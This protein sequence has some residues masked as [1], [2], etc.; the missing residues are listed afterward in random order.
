MHY[1]RSR[2][3]PKQLLRTPE[4]LFTGWGGPGNETKFVAGNSIDENL[5]KLLQLKLKKPHDHVVYTLH[6]HKLGTEG[7]GGSICLSHYRRYDV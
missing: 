5:M 6:W 1:L 2:L 4:L 7:V 3:Y